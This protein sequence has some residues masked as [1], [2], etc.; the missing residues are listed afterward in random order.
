MSTV[1]HANLCI[2]R[3]WKHYVEITFFLTECL[4]FVRIKKELNT[5]PEETL[6]PKAIGGSSSGLKLAS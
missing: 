5:T 1:W 2:P 6:Q 3:C 4:G